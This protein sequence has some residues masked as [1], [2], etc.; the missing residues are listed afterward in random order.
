MYK[1]Q[2]H[3]QICNFVIVYAIITTNEYIAL[4][5]LLYEFFL[6]D[7]F[8]RRV[9]ACLNFKTIF[10]QENCNFNCLHIKV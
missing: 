7:F 6:S 5:F 10:I 1:L 9:F 3:M 8:Y 4:Q 2:Q